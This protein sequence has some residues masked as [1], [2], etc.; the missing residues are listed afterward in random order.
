MG[1]LVLMTPTEFTIWL[2]GYI[3]AVDNLGNM[4]YSMERIKE[5]LDTVEERKVFE[6]FD[7]NFVRGT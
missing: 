3:E 5:Q 6:P 7:F 4:D 1:G 2:S